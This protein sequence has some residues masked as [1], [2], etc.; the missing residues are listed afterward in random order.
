MFKLVDDIKFTVTLVVTRSVLNYLLPVTC[1]P[2]AKDVDEAHSVD[3]IQSLK[4]TRENLKHS[5][6][7]YHENWYN[8]AKKK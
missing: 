3:L 1:K 6:K 2:Q 7:N 5:V 8:K 4:L